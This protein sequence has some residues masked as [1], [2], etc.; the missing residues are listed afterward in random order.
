MGK[1]SVENDKIFKISL[2]GYD[3]KDATPEQCSVHSGFDY[4]KIPEQL[5][6]YNIITMASSIPEGDNVVLT[7]DHNFGYTPC[8]LVYL[9]DIDDNFVTEFARLPFTEA[10]PIDWQFRVDMSSTQMKIIFMYDDIWGVGNMTTTDYPNIPTK[11]FAFK[12]QIWVND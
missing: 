8:W 2:P 11:R 10:L 7:I 3:A 1:I 6:G 9:D 5:E 12:Y 4:P